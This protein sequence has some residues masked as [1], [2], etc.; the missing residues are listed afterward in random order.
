M[1]VLGSGHTYQECCGKVICSGCMYAHEELT[2]DQLCPFCRAPAPDTDKELIE[3]YKKRVELN[4]AVAIYNMGSFYAHGQ[5]GL[6]QN[7]AK[8]LK[9]WHKAGELGHAKSYHNIG[10]TYLNSTVV[11]KDMKKARYYWGLAAIRGDVMARH[12]LGVSE[13]SSGNMDRALKHFMI[14]AMGGQSDSLSAVKEMF[15]DG[16]ATKD[17]YATAL[18][19]HQAYLDEIRS[20]QRDKAAADDENCKYLLD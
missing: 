9:L 2:V 12:N 1:P 7:M 19:Y 18:R 8:A 13:E 6:P 17:D 20:D 4:D 14:A 16:H 10:N 5:Y 3:G 11:E 15:M